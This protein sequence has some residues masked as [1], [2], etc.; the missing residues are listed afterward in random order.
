MTDN[1]KATVRVTQVGS[2]IGRRNDQRATLV[3]LG[4]NKMHRTRELEDTPSVRGMYSLFDWSDGVFRFEE[5]VD[6]RLDVF[7]VDLRVDDVLLRGLNRFDEMSAVRK[8]LHD[9]NFVLRYTSKPPGPEIFGDET[10]RSMYSAIDG[11]RTLAD[12]LLHVHGTEYRVKKFLYEL[13]ENGYVEIASI[14]QTDPPSQSSAD[15]ES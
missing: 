10:S 3:G 11:E 15:T 14:K 4:L 8:V 13:H 2:P 9:P 1:K 6:A 7:P 5:T 12:I